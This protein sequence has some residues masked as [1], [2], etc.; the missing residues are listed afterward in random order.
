MIAN[1]GWATFLF[2]A[3][4]DAFSAVFAWFFVKETMG[5]SLEQMEREFNSGAAAQMDEYQ[6]MKNRCEH[7]ERA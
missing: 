4:I 5:K 3:I 7:A 6:E 1:I 2:F